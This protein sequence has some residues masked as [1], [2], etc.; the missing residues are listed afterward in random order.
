ML[1]NGNYNNYQRKIKKLIKNPGIFFR[2][3]FNKHYPDINTEMGVDETVETALAKYSNINTLEIPDD[4][5]IDVVFTW[6]DNTDKQWQRKYEY[7]KANSDYAIISQ[8][9]MDSA[10]FDNHNELFYSIKAVEKYLPWVRKIYVITD[11]HIPSW[12]NEVPKITIVDHKE[13]ID[14]Q[15]LP[16]F[17]S[18]VIEAFLHRIPDLSENFI[19]F[20]DD[21]FVAKA[22]DKEHFFSA[23]SIGSLFV[24]AKN[25]YTMQ[26]KGVET[27]TLKASLR[28]VE[29][30]KRYYPYD[31][32]NSLVHTYFP[33]KKSGYEKAWNLFEKEIREFLPSKFRGYNDLNMA[34]FLVPWL[35]YCEAKAIEKIDICYYFNIRSRH[36]VTRYEKLLKLKNSND[37]PHSFCA[38]DF[39]SDS[40]NKLPDYSERLT[41]MLQYYYV[42]EMVKD[43]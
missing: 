3:Y 20:N 31:I 41:T 37:S 6:V 32:K 11:N 22:L 33:L 5:D 8:Y 43:E 42:E 18:H 17:N 26:K 24:S 25:L 13:I 40:G 16:T 39:K 7:N 36:A 14:N 23:N 35:L 10:R 34:S 1:N 15:Y 4:M 19:Y 30:L 29:L 21:V 27:P 12:I 28:S 38:N 2:D 9:A